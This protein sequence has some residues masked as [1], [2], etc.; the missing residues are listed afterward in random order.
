MEAREYQTL[1]ACEDTYWWHRGLRGILLECLERAGAG[2]SWRILDAGCGTGQILLELRERVSPRSVGFDASKEASAFWPK[3]SI[4][5]ACLAS[6]NTI[7]FR[8]STFDAVISVDV[9]C[10]KAVQV[11]QAVTEMVRVLRPGGWVIAVVPAYQWLLSEHDRAVHSVRRFT[12]SRLLGLPGFRSVQVVRISYLFPSLLIP[13]ALF[14]LL[15]WAVRGRRDS[16]PRSDLRPL[17]S[18]LNSALLF[19][20][21]LERRAF[22]RVDFPLGSSLILMARKP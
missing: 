12:R 13:L 11:D 22:R 8:P 21:N 20:V 4:G 9:L 19:L 6:I 18:W 14:R 15:R 16:R 17:P 3:R 7:P 10:C 2:P 5:A 1:F